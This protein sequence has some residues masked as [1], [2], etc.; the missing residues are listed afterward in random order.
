MQYLSA[1]TNLDVFLVICSETG[2]IV[3]RTYR[4]DVAENYAAGR[5]SLPESHTYT[6]MMQ[7]AALT[8]ISNLYL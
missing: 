7:D 1:N 5:N 3:L 8:E 6:V 4:K 2:Q